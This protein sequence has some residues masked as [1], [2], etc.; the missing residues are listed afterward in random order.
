M[1]WVRKRPCPTDRRTFPA[2]SPLPDA[3][4]CQLCF[5]IWA[6]KECFSVFSSDKLVLWAFSD[7]FHL[8]SSSNLLSSSEGSLYLFGDVLI[9]DLVVCLWFLHLWMIKHSVLLHFL[10]PQWLRWNCWRA[11][12]IINLSTLSNYGSIGIVVEHISPLKS[13]PLLKISI[14]NGVRLMHYYATFYRNP[15][16]TQLWLLLGIIIYDIFFRLRP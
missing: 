2:R 8:I 15:L 7:Y 5:F 14:L 3:S 16:R 1:P 4:P 9:V 10:V 6:S 12:K 11:V 13:P